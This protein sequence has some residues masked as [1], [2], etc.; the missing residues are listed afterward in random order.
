MYAAKRVPQV[1]QNRNTN[2]NLHHNTGQQPEALQC[3]LHEK[4]VLK[5]RKNGSGWEGGGVDRLEP[6]GTYNF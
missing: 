5:A 4:A 1:E 3:I 2:L 6:Q